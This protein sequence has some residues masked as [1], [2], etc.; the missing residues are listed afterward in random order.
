VDNNISLNTFATVTWGQS[1]THALGKVEGWLEWT[2][3]GKRVPDL[4]VS[5]GRE[6]VNPWNVP[7]TFC[8]KCGFDY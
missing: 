2:A 1:K 4:G 5:Y 3:C 7:D 8:P 6:D